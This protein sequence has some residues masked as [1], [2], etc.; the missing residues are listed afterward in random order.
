MSELC[1]LDDMSNGNSKWI[2]YFPSGKRLGQT[3]R[4]Q[5]LSAAMVLNGNEELSPT[6]C[7]AWQWAA[8]RRVALCPKQKLWSL[9]TCALV[10][11]YATGYE[12][13]WRSF[14]HALQH[15][16]SVCK[17]GELTTNCFRRLFQV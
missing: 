4:K 7:S 3:Q 11:S 14:F 10:L 16:F 12:R 8:I 17:R 5:R 2:I 15:C 1:M 6:C 13:L 9:E